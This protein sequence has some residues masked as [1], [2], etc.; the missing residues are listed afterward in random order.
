VDELTL[1]LRLI[2]SRFMRR[3]PRRE[4]SAA[5]FAAEHE[6]DQMQESEEQKAEEQDSE[7]QE[8]EEQE[9]DAIDLLE[10]Q[11]R[12]VELLFQQL[13]EVSDKQ[14]RKQLFVE[15]ADSLAAHG[16]IEELLFYPAVCTDETADQLH[17]AVGEHLEVKRVLAELIE[18]DVEDEQFT[19]KLDELEKLVEHH[20]EEEETRLFV[21]VRKQ[22]L[23][24][25]EELATQL[26]EKFAELK[27]NQPRKQIP[28]E[29]DGPAELPC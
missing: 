14:E 2:D 6:E 9:P 18:M 11:H 12:D 4:D 26:E 24:D 20:V 19:S 7:E 29:L 15:L 28:K 8:V 3:G 13:R 27:R 17:E 25:L 16:K 23:V 21:Q 22:E 1:G 5:Q 10:G